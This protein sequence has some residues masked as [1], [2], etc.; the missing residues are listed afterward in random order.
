MAEF[1]TRIQFQVVSQVLSEISQIV[2]NTS[3]TPIGTIGVREALLTHTWS[4]K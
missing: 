2:P 4:M 3:L 1:Y